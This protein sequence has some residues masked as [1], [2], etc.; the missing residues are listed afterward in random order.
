MLIMLLLV[1]RIGF[2]Q[3]VMNLLV[4]VLN[5]LNEFVNFFSFRLDMSRISLSSHKCHG[6]VNET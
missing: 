4:Y 6:Y 1:I 2:V 3:Y 5:V